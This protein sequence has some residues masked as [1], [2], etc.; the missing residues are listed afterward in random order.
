MSSS[1]RDVARLAGVSVATV[2]HVVNSTRF[3]AEKTRLKVQT[4]IDELQYSP[5]IVARQLKTGSHETV[6][7]I[8]PDIA[9]GYFA[10]II[11]EVEDVLQAHGV[12]LIV[13][14]TRER[15]DREL[16]GLRMLS[17]GVVD[18]VVVASTV[19]DYQEIAA[20]LPRDFPVVLVDRR[21][22]NAPVDVI[23]TDNS[24]AI[25]AGVAALIARGHR[26]IGFMASVG[27]LSTTA[28]RV[29]A[30]RRALRDHDLGVEEGL[31]SYL[32][33]MID[34]VQPSAETLLDNGC[35]AIV[36]SN[37]VL[38]HKLLGVMRAGA[39]AAREVE[40]LGYRDPA[41]FGYP[42]DAA[43]RLEEPIGE[44]GRLAGEAILQRI[45]DPVA[46]ARHTV[47]LASYWSDEP[48]GSLLSRSSL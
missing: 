12:R 14:N 16:D 42:Q 36:A 8:V 46:A 29:Q 48:A 44:M 15:A 24:A 40:I 32:E 22:R 17:S 4:A 31:I 2:S 27:H 9:N 45:A 33:S 41:N 11:E 5:N 28:E 30:Y 7:F 43:Q 18:G 47:L 6:G 10:T 20:V 13:A 38:T 26:R 3:V 39:L 25:R 19:D 35:T 34:P 21:L 37:N 1:I 23:T